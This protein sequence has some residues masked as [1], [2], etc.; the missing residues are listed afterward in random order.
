MSRKKY[1]IILSL[2]LLTLFCS[3][4]ASTWII[5]S[6]V[7]FNVAATDNIEDTTYI[8]VD[9]VEMSFS[10]F[11]DSS[12]VNWSVFL[13]E[14]NKNL[15]FTDKDNQPITLT[16]GKDY[17]S[18]IISGI[19][20]GAKTYNYN[21][22][23]T[24]NVY[25][26]TYLASFTVNGL[27]DEYQL[28][29]DYNSNTNSY[30]FLVKYKT[31]RIGYNSTEWLTIEDALSAAN[32]NST[33]ILADNKTTDSAKA[34]YTS[35]TSLPTNVTG[36]NGVTSGERTEY[37][38]SGK[39]RVPFSNLDLD[40]HGAGGE[41]ANSW[42]A[43]ADSHGYTEGSG[44][45]ITNSAAAKAANVVCSVL[46]IPKNIQLNVSGT[47]MIGGLVQN[48]GAVLN[49][50]VVVNDGIID[51]TGKIGAYGYLKEGT[52]KD[53]HGAATGKVIFENGSEATD[54]FKAFDWKGGANSN[55]FASSKV[56]PITA[57]S[58]HNISCESIFYYGSLYQAFW[59]FQF[60]NSLWSGY[61]RG[62]KNGYLKLIG[63]ANSDKTLFNMTSEDAYLIKK[64]TDLTPTSTNLSTAN[65]SNQTEGQ[66]D[67]FDFYGSF[68]DGNVSINITVSLMNFNMVTNTDMYLPVGFM[69]I[70]LKRGCSLTFDSA[71]YKFMPGSSL[72]VDEGANLIISGKSSA[73][74]YTI[75][76]ISD[77][78]N[79]DV[80][81]GNFYSS[82]CKNKTD[83]TFDVNG[84]VTV[85]DAGANKA[86]LGGC[87]ILSSE[88]CGKLIFNG[89]ATATVKNVQSYTK[90][91]LSANLTAQNVEKSA[92]GE[93]IDG[94][95]DFS[96]GNA[97]QHNGEYWA[98]VNYN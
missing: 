36:Y 42:R 16:Q 79:G 54:V 5:A 10:D 8:H 11:A 89:N 92:S 45:V 19:N 66:R 55:G 75:D 38:L 50:G 37:N 85:E 9:D 87:K 98:T 71:S 74:F 18:I 61:Q 6:S 62:D 12:S 91:T 52:S 56:F 59:T 73:Y 33:I 70:T 53:S 67:S 88:E 39:L 3:V 51:V 84:T 46:S 31:A 43:P 32:S 81:S 14:L 15:S 69:D 44:N 17:S 40:F 4:G 77:S 64:A 34:V 78:V 26:S 23:S 80:Y 90:T 83:A 94:Y 13:S 93:L 49:R 7:S 30:T 21:S 96:S 82:H 29:N 60:S 57:Y 97:Y 76:D 24:D 22:K 20:N 86:S 72:K 68:A 63:D 25:G 35:F 27:S 48:A 58:V 1:L 47:L 65:G 95:G 2:L 41:Y 28:L